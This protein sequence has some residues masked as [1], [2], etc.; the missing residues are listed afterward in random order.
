M[1]YVSQDQS[2]YMH[3]N[4]PEIAE[5]WDKEYPDQNIKA[6]PRKVV[7]KKKRIKRAR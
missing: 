4:H 5:R 7:G 1:P 6:L 2:I 3:I